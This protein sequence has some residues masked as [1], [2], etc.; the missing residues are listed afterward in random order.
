MV[1]RTLAA[2]CDAVRDDERLRLVREACEACKRVVGSLVDRTER[3]P[4][5]QTEKVPRAQSQ[6]G[7]CG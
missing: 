6:L 5:C 4:Q 7:V 3:L 1:D 2:V